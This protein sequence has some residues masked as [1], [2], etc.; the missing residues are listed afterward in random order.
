M[1]DF[2]QKLEDKDFKYGNEAKAKYYQ[3]YTLEK[4]LEEL[5]SQ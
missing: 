4:A 5:C 1:K 3:D 2:I